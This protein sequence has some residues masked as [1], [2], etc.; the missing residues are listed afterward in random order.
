MIAFVNEL[1]KLGKKA[2][3]D[4]LYRKHTAPYRALSAAYPASAQAHNQLAWAQAKCRRDLDD[5]LT[6]ARRAVE[7]DPK[8]TACLDT[9][10]ETYFQR[11]EVQQAI[12]IMNRCVELEPN[13]ERD[14]EQLE[15]FHK[16]PGGGKS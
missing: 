10:A 14:Q 1:D 7:L 6:Q 15:R 8:N 5:A 13:E 9:L 4:D 3:A 12:E 2:E 11:G 16:S